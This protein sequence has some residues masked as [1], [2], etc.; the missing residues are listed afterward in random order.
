VA[1]DDGVQN[2]NDEEFVLVRSKKC[3][4]TLSSRYPES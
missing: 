2:F 3:R 4:Q 1:V